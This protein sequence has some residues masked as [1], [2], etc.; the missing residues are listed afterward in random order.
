MLSTVELEIYIKKSIKDI[1]PKVEIKGIN[2]CVGYN[3]SPEGTYVFSED[4]KYHFMFTEKGRI[5]D[6]KELYDVTE[7]LL[8]VLNAVLFDISMEYA[9][10]N[11][12][13]GKD[14]R[15][16]LFKKEIELFS[17]FGEDFKQRKSKEI[18][19]ILLENP[20]EDE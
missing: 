18:Q 20:Y 7:V 1:L 2:F 13:E 10:E 16:S 11:R 6:D 3:N 4:G 5:S 8:N 9:I 15:R 17:M 12:I 19:E 14:F